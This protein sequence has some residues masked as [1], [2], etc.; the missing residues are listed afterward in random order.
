MR[1]VI[2]GPPGAGKGTQANEIVERYNIPHISTGDILRE[3]IKKG[4]D[5]G[6]EA[7]KYM[8]Q[9]NLVP[10]SLVLD[11]I[12]ERISRDDTKDGF[13]LD[14]FPRNVSQATA[15]DAELDKLGIKLDKVINIIVDPKK[16]IERATSRRVCPTCGET[17]NIVAKPPKVEGKCDKDGS[18][19]IIRS[20]D[21]EETVSRRIEVYTEQTSPLIDYY[22]AQ[23]TLFDVDGSQ[24]I[25]QVTE[26]IFKGLNK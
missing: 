24:S 6:L 19:L 15:L 20:D 17:Y 14:G 16:L 7:K 5:L 12:Q 23:G 25:E 21:T 1:L 22:K 2:L 11:L 18:D 8:D 10:D 13:L 4:T 9:G 3:N 26:D